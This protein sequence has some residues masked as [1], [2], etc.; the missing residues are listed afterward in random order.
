MSFTLED[1]YCDKWAA[2]NL[3]FLKW[4]YPFFAKP[5]CGC[6]LYSY[7]WNSDTKLQLWNVLMGLPQRY[8]VFAHSGV[9]E[10]AISVILSFILKFTLTNILTLPV[11]PFS[12]AEW[13]ED[14][15]VVCNVTFLSLRD[16]LLF[17]C[18]GAFRIA[19]TN[20]CF[21]SEGDVLY[22]HCSVR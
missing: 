8:S 14:L 3:F 18:N 7:F 2:S 15:R 10:F 4:L 22:P 5:M 13:S 19:S 20:R 17:F 16:L 12:R 1:V 21:Y 11:Y 9:H 6:V